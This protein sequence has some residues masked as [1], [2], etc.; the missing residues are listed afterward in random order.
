MFSEKITFDSFIRGLM[1]ILGCVCFC[2]LLNR[3][4]GVLWPFFVAWLLAYMIY[5]LVIFLEKKCHLRFR[6]LCILIALVIVLGA[7]TG[8]FFLIVPPTI[9]AISKLSDDFGNIVVKYVSDAHIQEEIMR[10]FDKNFTSNQ[11]FQIL[12]KEST[13]TAVQTVL[14]EAWEFLCGTMNLVF[15][16]LNVFVIFLYFFFILLDY[17]KISEGWKKMIPVNQR[18]TA[19]KVFEDVEVGM[20]KYFRGQALVASMVGI[21]FAIGFCIIDFPMAIGLGLF[22]GLLNMVPYLQLIGFLPT[23]ILALLKSADT[24]ESFWFIMVCALAVFAIVQVIQDMILTPRIM[25]KVMGL[26]PAVILLSLSV[27]GSLLGVIGLIIA[28]PLTTLVWSYY[29]RLVIGDNS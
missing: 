17:E 21:L 22:I 19:V 23:I 28:L 8:L 14:A 16:L 11:L 10:Y 25:G 26:N 9:D 4:S 13:M 18:G 6:A 29:K 27:W 20:N 24:G 15:G 2:L 3:L 1:I 5:P 7:V 12:Q